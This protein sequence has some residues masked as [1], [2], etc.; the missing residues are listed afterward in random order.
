MRLR[1]MLLGG[2]AALGSSL[3]LA[4]VHPLGNAGLY[5]AVPAAAAAIPEHTSI[6]PQAREVLLTKCADCHSAQTRAPLYGRFA[7]VSWLME[8]DIVEG[9]KH[10]NFAAWDSYTPD[11]QQTLE[12]KIL[13]EIKA[14]RMPLPQYRLLHPKGRVGAGDLEILKAWIHTPATGVPTRSEAAGEG[15][16]AEG[17]KVFARRCTGCHSLEQNREGPNLRGVY[18]AKAGQVSHFVYSAALR[19]SQIVWNDGTLDRWLADPDVFLP[20]N[21]MDFRVANPQERRD[22]IRYF[23]ESGERAAQP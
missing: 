21:N 5:A 11:Q 6:A 14:G 1:A 3:L 20:G 8:R 12:A 7:P 18:G 2:A 19:S 9:R 16:A 23:R 15:T 13:Q 4:R 17:R 10:L 22:L